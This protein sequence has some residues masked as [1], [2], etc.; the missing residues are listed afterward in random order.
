MKDIYI[1]GVGHNT[2][3]YIDLVEACG[4]NI[5]GLYH[6]QDGRTGELE[7]GYEILGT[8]EDLWSMPSLKGMNFALS[9]GDN[10]IRKDIFN[11]IISKGGD[12]PTL[13]HPKADVSRFAKL[14]KGTVVHIGSVVHPDVIIGNNTVLSFNVSVTHNTR[15]G[16][17]CYFALGAM[18]GAYVI[19]EDNVF[20]GI[21]AILISGKVE[22]IGQN[23]YIGAGALVTRSV[24]PFTVVA[25]FPAK[26]IK[27]LPRE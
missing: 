24:D 7:H 18:I 25:G 3:V 8:Y 16:D 21:G 12:V 15:I 10:A 20:I 27:E 2:T 11:R 23:A 13:V 19:I 1:L 5:K 14:G 4:Y 9:Q 17:N 22:R 26:P 6:F